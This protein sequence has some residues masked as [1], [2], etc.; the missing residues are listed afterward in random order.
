M[1]Y[2][3]QR[4]AGSRTHLPQTDGVLARHP[5]LSLKV[6]LLDLIIQQAI[7]LAC[8]QQHNKGWGMQPTVI[9]H[10]GPA[11]TSAAIGR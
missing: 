2:I 3:L 10:Q 11:A 9:E 4:Y 7:S 1:H 6:R 5:I 8:Q